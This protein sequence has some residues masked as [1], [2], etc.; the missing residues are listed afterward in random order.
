MTP[1]SGSLARVLGPW[2]ATAVV[3]GTI[4]GSGVFKKAQAVTTA[5]PD[6]GTAMLAWVLGGVLALL[7]AFALAEVAVR[8]PYSGGNYVFLREGYG[9]WAGFLWGWVEFWII[10]SASIAALAAIF[11]DSLHDVLRHL[12]PDPAA[13]DGDVLDFWSRQLLA[14]AVILG[15]A[16][17]N[18]RGT[19]W[20]GN[21][22]VV[23]T[24]VKV[25][26][27]IAL[28][29]LPVAAA[30]L[31]SDPV[32][33]PDVARLAP[34]WPTEEAPFSWVQFGG[35]LVG[36]LW[37]YHG[38]MNVAPIAGEVQNPQRNLPLALLVGTLTVTVLYL[39][40]N[41]AYY[42]VL[43]RADITGAT[44]TTVATVFCLRVLG[45]AGAVVASAAVMTS[46]FGSLNGNLLVGPRLLYAMGEDGLAPR[47][48][49]RVDPRYGTPAL[50]I[51]GL[52][53]W[54][55]LLTVAVAVM[56]QVRLPV[57]K[58][59]GW[60]LDVNLPPGKAPFDVVTDFAM[61]GAVA[62]ET[63][64]VAAVF[65]LRGFGSARELPYRCPGYPLVPL[66]YVAIM[67]A[68]LVN[69][70]RTQTSEAITGVGFVTL[71][72]LVYAVVFAGRAAPA[73]QG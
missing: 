73:R 70:F 38:W 30:A 53:G 8:L 60:S 18:V 34:W 24:T 44:T 43:P 21:L 48:L 69:M 12:H 63:M 4:I 9:R 50:A 54:A 71:G 64:A 10:R 2:T 28:A 41:F 58:L 20:G 16:W 45:S 61:F 52:A 26:S 66:V 13:R 47:G 35:A 46:V 7:G 5:L 72:A 33:R 3:I 1:A 37:A 62:F 56:M 51:L 32:R 65:R 40:V 59:G 55:C 6:F 36:V 14:V 27:L 39:G 19:R 23:L 57:L 49:A 68:V 15:L 31:L 29:L 22:Q 42:L 17:V 67:A 11:A 25:G